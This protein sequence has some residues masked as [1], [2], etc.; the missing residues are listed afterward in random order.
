MRR[1]LTTAL[2][3]SLLFTFTAT[4]SA[5]PSRSSDHARRS[6]LVSLKAPAPLH[7]ELAEL[8]FST[9]SGAH[10]RTVI[11]E[12]IGADYVA[13]ASLHTAATHRIQILVLIFDRATALMDPSRVG[14]RVRLSRPAFS[15]RVL[16]APEGFPASRST[17]ESVLCRHPPERAPLSEGALRLLSAAGTP[18]PG[19]TA[20]GAI[21]QAYDATCALPYQASF[22]QAVSGTPAP[23]P[24]PPAP[25]PPVR[26]PPGCTPCTAP[27]GYACPLLASP[28]ICI[29]SSTTPRT[30]RPAH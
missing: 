21:S 19:Y 4:A 30:T 9:R 25:S 20:V 3:T 11:D 12:P 6:W 13:S 16:E 29:A 23:S 7:Y 15:P 14:L 18:L 22:E 26:Q 17:V 8:S 2:G 24:A 5:T 10:A 1:A 28:G 27:P